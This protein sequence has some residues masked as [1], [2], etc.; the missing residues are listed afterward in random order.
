MNEDGV[1]KEYHVPAIAEFL[2]EALVSDASL[3]EAVIGDLR[4]E[5]QRVA[6]R[7]TVG[8]ATR[9]YWSQLAR[10]TIPFAALSVS[11]GSA[12][13][14]MRF[15][16]GVL[17]GYAVI[18]A[19]LIVSLWAV[20]WA[21]AFADQ[22]SYVSGVL[23]FGETPGLVLVWSFVMAAVSGI[24][25]GYVAAR[26]GDRTAVATAL[27]LGLLGI[28]LCAVTIVSDIA[29]APIWFQAALSAV[30]LPSVMGGALLRRRPAT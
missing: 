4:E 25:A 26:V 16:A 11:R 9:W 3:R 28:P 15:V 23:A 13:D 12:L 7:E 27:T 19:L 8:L 29:T 21:F 24:A 14:K 22:S 6:S 2:M 10:S 20:G 5:Y 30:L 18:I 17:G 1:T